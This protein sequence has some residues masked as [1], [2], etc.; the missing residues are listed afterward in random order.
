M[1]IGARLRRE[2]TA[3]GADAREFDDTRLTKILKEGKELMLVQLWQE[4]GGPVWRQA[5]VP[6]RGGADLLVMPAR[7]RTCRLSKVWP[8]QGLPEK[9][10]AQGSHD[11]RNTQAVM[12]GLGQ[13]SKQG[14]GKRKFWK[15]SDTCACISLV[16]GIDDFVN[17]LY[18]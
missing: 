10:E 7:M 15:D 13:A 18:K 16:C 2:A 3:R 1:G 11:T 9:S 4:E 5:Q 14:G 12:P 8:L 17:V 6:D